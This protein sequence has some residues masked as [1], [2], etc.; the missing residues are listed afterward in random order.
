MFLNH[1]ISFNCQR[2]LKNSLIVNSPSNK[3]SW[4]YLLQVISIITKHLFLLCYPFTVIMYVQSLRLVARGV[5]EP[6]FQCALHRWIM[7]QHFSRP[8]RLI[9]QVYHCSIIRCV[10][11]PMRACLAYVPLSPMQCVLFIE[12]PTLYILY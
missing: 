1:F 8:S 12:A 9:D 6:K 11:T 4:L 5:K 7:N 2:L 10:T 3:I